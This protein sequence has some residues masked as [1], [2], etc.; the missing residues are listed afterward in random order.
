MPTIDLTPVIMLHSVEVNAFTAFC[1]NIGT[2]KLASRNSTN[3]ILSL[4]IF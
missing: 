3:A 2:A 4:S 1:A